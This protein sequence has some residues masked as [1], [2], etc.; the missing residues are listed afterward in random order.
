M[1]QI[2]SIAEVASARRRVQQREVTAAC[3]QI[4]EANLHLA[5]YRFSTASPTERPLR[6]RQVRQLAELLEYV[7]ACV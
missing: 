7:T 6:A 1:A 3:V 2:I 5:L 4:V